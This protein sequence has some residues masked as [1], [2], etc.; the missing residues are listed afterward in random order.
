MNSPR[1]NTHSVPALLAIGLTIALLGCGG[2]DTTSDNGGFGIGQNSDTSED[3]NDLDLPP[4][5]E[6]IVEEAMDQ[7]GV[8]VDIQDDGGLTMSDGNGEF[9][10]GTD[11]DPPDWLASD[12][13][14]P[15]DISI[16][17]FG[18]EDGVKSL[19]STQQNTFDVTL[20]LDRL[21]DWF[22]SN[23][24]DL[25]QDDA[26]NGQLSVSA[27]SDDGEVID[28]QI[29]GDVYSLEISRRDVSFDRQDAAEL[30]EGPGTA[31]VTVA[32][33]TYEVEGTCFVQ[34]E[35]YRFEHYAADGTTN[36]TVNISTVVEP[37]TGSAFFMQLGE[38]TFAQYVVNFPMGNGNEPVISIGANEFGVSGDLID[39]SATGSVPGSFA[40]K[41]SG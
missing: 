27:A 39:M 41:C 14:L 12:F 28:V 33:E 23:G 9:T 30:V 40:V 1:T 7:A 32:G 29:R 24:Y 38:G 34:G 10:M 15:A 31:T 26:T 13:P 3:L 2:D 36:V 19:F 8:D 18:E 5:V 6:Q 21:A 35:E 22:A 16:Q 20:E 17:G 4:A 25:L 11:L 37:A